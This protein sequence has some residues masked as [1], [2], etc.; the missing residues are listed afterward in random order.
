MVAFSRTGSQ[1]TGMGLRARYGSATLDPFQPWLHRTFKVRMALCSRVPAAI[2]LDRVR[3]CRRGAGGRPTPRKHVHAI[4]VH[5][6]RATHAYS[7]RVKEETRSADPISTVAA[8]HG[9]LVVTVRARGFDRARLSDGVRR[10]EGA[11]RSAHV[12]GKHWPEKRFSGGG[13]GERPAPP[14]PWSSSARRPSE[15]PANTGRCA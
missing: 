9:G 2:G 6:I 13:A 8:E 7:C 5:A 11:Q 15:S 10:F 1:S 14:T 12:L 4:R 3:G